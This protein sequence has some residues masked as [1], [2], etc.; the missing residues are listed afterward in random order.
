MPSDQKRRGERRGETVIERKKGRQAEDRERQRPGEIIRLDKQC[1]AEP[2]QAADEIAEA[3]EP[4][5]AE[6]GR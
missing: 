6:G 4:A 2:P 1:I 3:E 5:D